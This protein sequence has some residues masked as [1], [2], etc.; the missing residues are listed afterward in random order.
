MSRTNR[1]IFIVWICGE[2]FEFSLGEQRFYKRE[3]F[4]YPKRCQE[5]RDEMEGDQGLI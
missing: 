5:C 2:R 3:S 4:S 1:L